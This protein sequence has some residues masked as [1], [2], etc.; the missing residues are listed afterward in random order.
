MDEAT[1]ANLI[2]LIVL[3]VGLAAFTLINRQTSIGQMTK[4]LALWGV[5]FVAV[6]MGVL[7]WTDLRDQIL[8]QQVMLSDTIVTTPRDRDG[9]F[10]LTLE[11]NG[12]PI[13]FVVDT[14][15]TGIVLSRNHASA[16]GIDTDELIFIGR[17]RT[18]NGPVDT[19]PVTLDT[20]TLGGTTDTNVRAVVNNGA[21]DESLLGMSY[22][23]RFSRL[24][25]TNG[26]LVLE[27]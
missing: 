8:P 3:L 5:I 24:E 17:A 22:L 23:S 25:I 16:A 15:A 4:A 7:L 21:L 1:T 14:G 20:L 18:A 13:R 12:T 19:A 11:V 2:Y 6:L 10:Y 9:H 27:R 26:Q